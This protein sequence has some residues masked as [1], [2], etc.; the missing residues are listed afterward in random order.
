LVAYAK[1]NR[2]LFSSPNHAIRKAA[3][4]I[5]ELVGYERSPEMRLISGLSHPS[6]LELSPALDD[7][8][9]LIRPFDLYFEILAE[10]S[11]LPTTKIR[12]RVIQLMR[13][14][15]PLDTWS[16]QGEN[17]LQATLSSARLRFHYHRPCAVLARRVVFHM[18]TEFIEAGTLGSVS[19][20]SMESAL[21][22]YDPVM[23]LTRP[24]SRPAEVRPISGRDGYG[25]SNGD[26]L[27]R[28]NEAINPVD[29]YISHGNRILAEETTLKRPEWENPTEIRRSAIYLS[30]M[31]SLNADDSYYPFSLKVSN[32]LIMEYASLQGNEVPMP[33]IIYNI[34]YGHDSPGRNWLALSPTVGYLLGWKLTE[35][36][37]FRW[38]N[39][40][41]AM[42]AE[43]IWWRGGCIEQSPPNYDDE[44][45]E[46][47]LVQASELAW[48]I[49]T[50]RFGTLKRLISIKR[51]FYQDK[52][53]IENTASSEQII[54]KSFKY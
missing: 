53:R 37:L 25:R 32:R 52:Q 44:V 41:G 1:L 43:S 27:S 5:A 29:F 9:I 49:I 24:G 45:G 19:F 17:R 7:L 3:R 38:I 2:R 46:G 36:G 8:D 14:L 42:M 26:W 4:T 16:T 54:N 23:L 12:H 11:G 15:A 35:H 21:R 10:E 51:S 31:P 47:W 34:A 18:V 20:Q 33:L 6:V 50:S 39:D 28:V 22:F 48:D 30:T 13:Q 40:E